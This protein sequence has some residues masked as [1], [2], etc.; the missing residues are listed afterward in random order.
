MFQPQENVNRGQPWSSM[1]VLTCHSRRLSR[2][3]LIRRA[4]SSGRGAALRRRR[5]SVR[6]RAPGTV[7]VG[8]ETGPLT[9]LNRVQFETHN[10]FQ[11]RPEGED[12]N[13]KLQVSNWTRFSWFTDCVR[14]ACR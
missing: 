1:W 4:K 13:W 11:G 5:Q 9:D 10:A 8:L 7:R 2:A 3:L 14:K 6:E 12:L